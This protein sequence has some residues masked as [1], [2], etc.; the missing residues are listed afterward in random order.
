M[1]GLK[2]FIKFLIIVGVFA[3][4]LGIG[5]WYVRSDIGLLGDETLLKI[6]STDVLGKPSYG[7]SCPRSSYAKDVDIP[8]GSN[9]GETALFKFHPVSG[10]E[11]ECPP[12]SVI[13]DRKTGEA[14]IAN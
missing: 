13:V 1:K 10:K 8:A 6:V 14:W 7:K 2:Y 5:Y 3:T 12:L 9:K 11:A 4:L